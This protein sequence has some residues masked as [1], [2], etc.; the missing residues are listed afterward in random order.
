[1]NLAS[2]RYLFRE[3]ASPR[4]KAKSNTTK[5]NSSEKRIPPKKNSEPE[6]NQEDTIDMSYVMEQL[7]IDLEQ[8]KLD[9]NHFYKIMMKQMEDQDMRLRVLEDF[10]R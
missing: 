10:C 3:R 7:R 2:P 1:M 8:I 9:F 4:T 5:K 6:K